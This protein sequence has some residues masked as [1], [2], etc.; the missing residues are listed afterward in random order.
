MLTPVQDGR[1]NVECGRKYRKPYR[2]IMEDPMRSAGNRSPHHPMG[3]SGVGLERTMVET[4]MPNFDRTSVEDDL[5]KPAGER[6]IL[7]RCY[8]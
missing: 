4:G 2:K 5:N 6:Y 7:N 1:R 3:M 8:T